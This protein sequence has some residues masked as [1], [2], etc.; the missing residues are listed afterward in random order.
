MKQ[1]ALIHLGPQFLICAVLMALSLAGSSPAKAAGT[2]GGV[3]HCGVP[4]F[5][6]ISLEAAR[7]VN[8]DA[9]DGLAFRIDYTYIDEKSCSVDLQMDVLNNGGN[10]CTLNVVS[11]VIGDFPEISQ[12]SRGLFLS[13][14]CSFPGITAC[15]AALSVSLVFIS[16]FTD[17]NGYVTADRTVLDPATILVPPYCGYN[18][19]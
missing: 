12:R 6:S 18:L 15:D 19:I 3:F 2:S 17:A 5:L 16:L 10:T 8:S 9:I 1:H 13:T 11:A 14:G 7:I 4:T